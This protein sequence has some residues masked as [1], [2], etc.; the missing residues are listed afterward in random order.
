MI[1]YSILRLIKKNHTT[2]D[3]SID[4]LCDL[5]TKELFSIYKSNS[6]FLSIATFLKI[7]IIM[8]LILKIIHY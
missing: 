6:K 2:L 4:E 7:R 5:T 3:L 1:F 8:R